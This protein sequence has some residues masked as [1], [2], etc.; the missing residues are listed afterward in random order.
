[1]KKNLYKL[2]GFSALALSL[3]ACANTNKVVD[4]ASKAVESVEEK[5]S[6]VVEEEKAESESITVMVP[7][8]AIPSDE[9]LKEFTDSTG[10]QVTMNKVDWDAIRDKIAIAASG[11]ESSA[12]VVEV[13]WSWVGEFN[14][15]D[16][17]EPLEVSEEDKKDMTTLS[18]FT[19]DGKVL[20]IPYSN[21]FR[22]AYY[23]TKQFEEAGLNKAPE[24]YDEVYESMKAIKEAGKV[25]HPYPLV[26]TAE[27]KT[28][29][30]LVWTAYTMNGKVFNDDNTLNEESVKEALAF[31]KKMIDEGLVDPADKTANGGETYRR[32]TGG[33]ASYLTGPTAYVA[34]VN[35]PEKSKVV[36]E[37]T[38]ILMPGKTETA[39][40]TMALPEALGI[41]KFSKNKEAAKKFIEWYT[42]SD[43]Q[44]KLNA[45]L[46]NLPTRNSVLETLINDGTIKNAG[47]MLE[48]A[49]R[50]DSPFPN[51]VP[52][53]YNEMSNAIY[54]V[55][56]EMALNNLSVDE[57]F[58]K[59]D[60][61]LKEIIKENE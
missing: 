8:W 31:Y 36:D 28:F 48:Q 38:P 39:K 1:M 13:D 58:T 10:I 55:V 9:L 5:V 61:R 51:G 46:G 53:Y 17:L 20:A 2:A 40:N 4:E 35:N 14:A 3:A 11:N 21:D 22:I 43:V 45:E 52:V 59:M 47:A 42:S 57:A 29:T 15:A 44:V 19:A 50:I 54:N 25:E 18:T 37:V 34:N 30:G 27:E 23:N 41:T 16:W 49:K 24:T 56:N 26:L 33:T 32:L 60:E 12:D 7:D 6:E